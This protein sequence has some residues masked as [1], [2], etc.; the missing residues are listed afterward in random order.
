MSTF[1]FVD[2]ITK[3]EPGIGARGTFA[4]P[5]RLPEFRASL[6]AEAIGQL[7]AWVSM[8]QLDFKL[9]PV[10]GIAGK[11]TFLRDVQ[12]GDL[13]DLRVTISSCDE[14]AVGYSG[15]AFVEGQPVLELADC[16][17]PMLPAADFDD[18]DEV[19]ARFE[20]LCAEG[21]PIEAFPGVTELELEG[22]DIHNGEANAR[23]L[24]PTRA[25]FL[26]DHFPRKAV[27]PGTLLLD[28]QIRLAMQLADSIA[29]DDNS[30]ADSVSNVK[31]RS[32]VPPGSKVDLSAKILSATGEPMV[33]AQTAMMSG[34]T[35]ST[36][37]MTIAARA[38]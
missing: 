20:V 19:H 17:G 3:L 2:R 14:A 8:A 22:V 27:L 28:A 1:S 4:V 9:R 31:A 6:I 15:A 12:P 11:V 16:V 29:A 5:R 24:V 36:G 7:A 10:A 13:L 25:A 37:R 34:K 38:A 33:I 26:R 35:V 23:L 30:K 21:V 18:P 32:F